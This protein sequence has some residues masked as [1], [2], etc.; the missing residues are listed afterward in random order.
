MN[1]EHLQYLLDIAR[2]QSIN[3][4]AEALHLQRSY[5]SKV[6]NNLERQWGV[7][8]FERVP[9]GVVPTEEGRYALEEIAAAMAILNRLEQHF[10]PQP[11]ASSYP[12]YR[13]HL[14]L[15]HPAKMRC[16]NQL[17]TVVEQFQQQFPNVSLA[18]MEK[19]SALLNQTLWE[20]PNQLAI[21]VHSDAIQ[22]LNWTIPEKL[23]FVT[24]AELPIVAL[25]ADTHPL[26][27]SYQTISLANLCKQQMILMDADVEQPLFYDLLAAHGKPDIKHIISGNMP[28]FYQLLQTGRYFSLGI[29]GTDL[30]DGLRQIPLRET[31]TVTLGLLFDP[32]VLEN[33]PTKTLLEDILKQL[34]QTED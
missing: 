21:V 25:A 23:R 26:A 6:V 14:V 10:L 3:Q 31:I 17:I 15:Y 32:I 29:Y 11:K 9:K 18:L 5:L 19:S 7:T 24:I 13:D 33:F 20:Q 4:A 8:L 16:R 12:K 1:T 34:K 28:L 27:D 2:Y 30:G 22:Y